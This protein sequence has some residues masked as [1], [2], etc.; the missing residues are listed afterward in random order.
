MRRTVLFLIAVALSFGS[1]AA[2]SSSNTASPQERAY[3][4]SVEAIGD[5]VL[6]S[7][8]EA[9]EQDLALVAEARGWTL[10]EA[11]AYNH[12]EEAIEQ[13]AVRVATV[14]PDVFVGS[15]LSSQADGAPT[16][17]IKGPADR[18]I[19]DIANQAGIAIRIA[20]NQPYSFDELE[21]RKL[22]VHRALQ[23]HGFS[24]LVT[25]ADI[26][27]GGLIEVSLTAEPGSANAENELVSL[28][29]VDL[30][31]SVEFTIRE[32]PTAVP[33]GAFG[34]MR[35]QGGS[36]CTSGWTVTKNS[37]GVR[38]VT[39]AG[40]CTGITQIVHP[41]VGV[42]ATTFQAQH[43]G[44]WGDVEW[45]TTSQFEVDDFYADA[46]NVRDVAAVEPRAGIAVG[47]TIC[48]YGRSSNQRNC[49]MEV[50]DASIACGA[51]S[52]LVQMN[53][54]FVIGGDSGGG[55]SWNFTAYGSTF[56]SCDALDSF[57]VADLF[58]EALGISVRTS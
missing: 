12:A 46:T 34:G 21:T 9:L 20:D 57:S 58:D 56:G 13:V 16:L 26:T 44:F 29:P 40:H 19:L 54:G 24:Q 5:V 14:R 6:Q 48:V 33:A 51:M 38:G 45:Y 17:Y 18:Q 52:T 27:R 32:T 41:G 39:G 30:R 1:P 55:W 43:I 7:P 36:L 23:A 4:P 47:E 37:S 3:S 53:D 10:E 31:S 50:R 22:Q 28:I 11:A 35:L 49:S 8:E 25:R 42:F 2:A 15:E